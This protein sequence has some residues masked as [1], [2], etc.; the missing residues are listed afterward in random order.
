ME[1][2]L[3]AK[4]QLTIDAQ[5]DQVWK[6]LTDPAM[7]KQYMFGADVQ[8]E[9]KPGSMITWRGEWKGK[10]YEDKGVI[11]EIN[12]PVK[13]QYTHFSPLSGEE[14]KPGNYHIVT[15][16]LT[17]DHTKTIVTLTQDKNATEEAKAHSEKN[18]MAMLTAMKTL[19]EQPA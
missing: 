2:D 6:A 7:I 12:P 10:S 4:A 9:W 17:D 13:L 16:E 11:Q 15:I 3:I 5:A 14:D 1:N 19:L 8:S 18:W